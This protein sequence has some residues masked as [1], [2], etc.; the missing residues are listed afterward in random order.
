MRN[1]GVIGNPI[2][3]SWSPA[4]FRKKF[5]NLHLDNHS[6]KAIHITDITTVRQQLKPFSLSGFNVTIP[7]KQSIIPYLDEISHSA[8]AINAV[9][10][11]KVLDSKWIGYNTDYLG[12]S[13]SIL[14]ALDPKQTRALIFGTG[15]SSL[16]IKYV[17]NKLGILYTYV[18]RS[19]GIGVT[20][21]DINEVIIAE[22]KLLINTTPVGMYPNVEDALS[23][24]YDGIS[25]RHLC[26]DLVYNP[27]ETVF[28]SKAKGRGAKVMNGLQMLEIQAEEAWRIWSY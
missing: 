8:S 2:E 9:N 7:Y 16:A 25:E 21:S 3:H 23:I 15:G 14:G 11:V 22:H 20:Y 10:T 28:L 13:K 26:F 18:S 19:K 6:Y 27:E 4:Y 12:F 5:E 1:Y 17:L 24:P